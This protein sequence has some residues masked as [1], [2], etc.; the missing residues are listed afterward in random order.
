MKKIKVLFALMC[1]VFAISACKNE[2]IDSI[3]DKVDTMEKLQIASISSQVKAIEGTI[4]SLKNVPEDLGNYLPV[5][6]E[7][8]MVIE[9]SS[10]TVSG[11][12]HDLEN[13]PPA[14]D[15]LARL[16]AYDVQLGT[17]CSKISGNID[18]CVI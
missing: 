15:V 8:C 5:L 14:G 6:N 18:T 3:Q 9:E 17:S 4:A 11:F 7:L 16:M 10:E 13:Q 12:I 1:S 2:E